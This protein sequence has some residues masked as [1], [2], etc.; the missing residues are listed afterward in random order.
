MRGRM[1]A[2]EW[3]AICTPSTCTVPCV[4]LTNPL[5]MR[6]SVD[7]PAPEAPSTTQ[8]CPAGTCSDTPSSARVPSA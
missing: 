3:A 1:R 4:G 5:A 2:S 7:L 8:N 6:S